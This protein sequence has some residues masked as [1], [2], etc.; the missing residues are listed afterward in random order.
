MFLERCILHRLAFQSLRIWHLLY[1]FTHILKMPPS[2]GKEMLI[3]GG[4]LYFNKKEIC[5]LFGKR[6]KVCSVHYFFRS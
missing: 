1:A 2:S 3:E 6:K 4:F 5:I